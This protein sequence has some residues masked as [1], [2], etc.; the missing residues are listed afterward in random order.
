MLSKA[1]RNVQLRVYLDRLAVWNDEL[2]NIDKSAN[3]K[4]AYDNLVC[5]RKKL[6]NLIDEIE[7]FFDANIPTKRAKLDYLAAELLTALDWTIE[8]LEKV[9]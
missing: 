2:K 6:I 7:V 8:D 4:V 3:I 5:M 9:M 1:E